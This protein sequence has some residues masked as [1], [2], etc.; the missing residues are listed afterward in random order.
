M[1]ANSA[2]APDWKSLGRS[3]QAGDRKSLAR[4]ISLVENQTPG[5]YGFMATLQVPDGVPILGITGPPGAGKST[6]ADQL[7]AQYLSEN[8]KLAVLCVDPSSPFHQGALLGDR[9]RMSR[10]YTDPRVFIRSLTTRGSMGGLHPG[11]ITITDLVRSAGFD[12]I[13]VET[14]G[15]GQ[16]EVEIARL[17]DTVVVVLVPESGDEIQIMKAGLLEIADLLVVNKSDRPGAELLARELGAIHRRR[18]GPD[19]TGVPVIRTIASEN[20]GIE[21]LK[22]ALEARTLV[23]ADSEKRNARLAEKAFQLIASRKIRDSQKKE[24][25]EKIQEAIRS[26]GFNLYDWVISWTGDS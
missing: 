14:V 12:L 9:I 11:M 5:Y 13:L 22:S 10:W 1:N 24:M 4:A 21:E 15:V 6:L 16:N 3:I 20:Q 8:R 7:I 19:L 26:P 25:L 18:T 23:A 2:V 17:A